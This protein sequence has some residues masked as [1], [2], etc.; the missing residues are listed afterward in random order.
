MAYRIEY[1]FPISDPFGLLGGE[2]AIEE[3]LRI[4]IPASGAERDHLLLLAEAS[5]RHTIDATGR[6]PVAGKATV[7]TNTVPVR[8]ELPF[9]AST[10]DSASYLKD[11]ETSYTD[12]GVD[13]F[14]VYGDHSP[15]ILFSRNAFTDPGDTELDHPLPFKFTFTTAA[16]AELDTEAV[17]DDPDTAEVDETAARVYQTPRVFQLCALLFLSHLYENRQ[18]VAY[19]TSKAIEVPLAFRHLVASIARVK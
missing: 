3:H 4:D 6:T 5:I 10:L 2:T 18:A 19:S 15:S 9:K 7:H 17:A 14:G 8:M 1:D 16:D 12:L 11:G 13:K